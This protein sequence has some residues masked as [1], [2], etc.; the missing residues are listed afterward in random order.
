MEDRKIDFAILA[1]VHVLALAA[2]LA[3]GVGFRALGLWVFV[4]LATV[5]V[6]YSGTALFTRPEPDIHRRER[7]VPAGP[8]DRIDEWFDADAQ[9]SLPMLPSAYP[10][11]LRFVLPTVFLLLVPVLGIGGALT[12][13][14][15]GLG[16][17]AGGSV[18]AFF[19]Q[20]GAF[21]RPL[22]AVIGTLIT[23]A[24][25]G[26]FYRCHVATGRYNRLTTHMML[27][28]QVQYVLWYTFLTVL[29]VLYA[30]LTL[31]VIGVGVGPFVG[32]SAG[33]TVWLAVVLSTGCLVKFVF[34]WSRIRGERQ[35]NVADDSFT[36]NFSPTPPDRVDR[37]REPCPTR[38]ERSD[39]S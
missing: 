21:Q 12:V 6:L 3:L 14:G 13:E 24:Q 26:R 7:V 39:S 34:E 29:F 33:R 19:A 35:P 2:S 5:L 8:V 1:S 10:K 17:R 20:F 11:N 16:R 32:D 36:A 22:V 25:A 37:S 30:V 9:V 28:M 31:V 4:E 23:L 27:E 15:W 18:T 38:T